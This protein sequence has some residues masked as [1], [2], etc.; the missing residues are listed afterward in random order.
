MTVALM[1][2]I[3]Q[4]HGSAVE[5]GKGQQRLLE[6]TSFKLSSLLD[7]VMVQLSSSEL[8]FASRAKG[9]YFNI[10]FS[11]CKTNKV[12]PNVSLSSF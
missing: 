10:R 5:G 6:D 8:Q 2:P 7:C 12:D 1:P 4:L 9:I 11:L 3:T